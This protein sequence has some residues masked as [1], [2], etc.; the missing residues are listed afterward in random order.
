MG[1]RHVVSP[2]AFARAGGSVPA[3]VG[4]AFPRRRTDLLAGERHNRLVLVV[5]ALRPPG[6]SDLVARDMR[7]G[8]MQVRVTGPVT[9]PG[10]PVWLKELG[11]I[12][13]LVSVGNMYPALKRLG[14]SMT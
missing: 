6:D 13:R 1:G 9:R 3:S 5:A 14:I 11:P 4:R 2:C 7:A 8:P 10:G 12:I